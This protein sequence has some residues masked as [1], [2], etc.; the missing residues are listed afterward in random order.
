ETVGHHAAPDVGSRNSSFLRSLDMRNRIAGTMLVPLVG[1]AL[2]AG[3]ARAQFS[4]NL[5]TSIRA[6]G[7]GGAGAAVTWGEPGV[8]A[9]PATLAGVRGLG[10]AA[11]DTH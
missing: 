6:A 5:D 8:W 10:W 9:N 2:A 7:M 4:L 11:G 3:S 1:L